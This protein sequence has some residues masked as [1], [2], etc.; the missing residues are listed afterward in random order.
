MSDRRLLVE[1][2]LQELVSDAGDA[3]EAGWRPRTSPFK[4]VVD[5]APAGA[6]QLKMP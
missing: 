6:V 2:A 5:W 3:G 1:H 4:G